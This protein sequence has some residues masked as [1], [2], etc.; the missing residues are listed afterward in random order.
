[1]ENLSL[2]IEERDCLGSAVSQVVGFDMACGKDERVTRNLK[3]AKHFTEKANSLLSKSE[4]LS[5]A[6]AVSAVVELA[7]LSKSIL[8]INVE[9]SPEVAMF[10]VKAFPVNTNYFGLYKTIFNRAVYL[11][12]PSS[13]LQIQTLEDD[14]IELIAN[15]KDKAMGAV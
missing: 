9:Y 3:K 13:R 8:D 15:A 12:Q 7:I 4:D 1:M 11:D 14:L 2:T 10:S 6:N 5:L